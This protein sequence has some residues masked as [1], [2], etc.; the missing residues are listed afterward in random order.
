[1]KIKI[2]LDI[3][4][5]SNKKWFIHGMSKPPFVSAEHTD[6]S[7]VNADLVAE[8]VH[9]AFRFYKNDFIFANVAIENMPATEFNWT[10][11][12]IEE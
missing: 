5:D 3:E 4:T 1:M 9:E 11:T 10:D 6:I 8:I 2:I 7:I 12:P